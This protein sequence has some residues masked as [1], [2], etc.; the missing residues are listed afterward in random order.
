MSTR[1]VT[2]REQRRDWN[3]IR[4]LKDVKERFHNRTNEE[5]A[6]KRAEEIVRAEAAADMF[7][8]LHAHG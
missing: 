4:I 1:L 2:L 6:S 8:P 3:N 5:D 7:W